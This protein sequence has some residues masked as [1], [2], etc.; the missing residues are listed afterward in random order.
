MDTQKAPATRTMVHSPEH[1]RDARI[2]LQEDAT[3]ERVWDNIWR[4]RGVIMKLI[5]A[6]RHG[7]H[8]LHQQLLLDILPPD[9][10]VLEL[11]CGTASLTLSLAPRFHRLVGLDISDEALRIAETARARLGIQNAEFV[12]GDC[13]SA[14]FTDAFDLVWSAGL[15]E[16]FFDDDWRIVQEHLRAAKPG[17]VALISVPS[18][19]SLHHLHY[20]VTRPTMLRRFWPWSDVRHF[21]KFYSPRE[22]V[23]VGRRSFSMVAVQ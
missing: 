14:P 10:D 2:P 12:K 7:L 20:L 3:R 17:G 4:Q 21:Q 9:A 16:H 6:I 1:T 15:I 19:Y 11:G 13:R 8:Q 5:A 22:L 18:T 23:A